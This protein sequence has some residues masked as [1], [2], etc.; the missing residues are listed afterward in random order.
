MNLNI[1]LNWENIEDAVVENAVRDVAQKAMKSLKKN[2]DQ[3][4]NVDD[5]IKRVVQQKPTPDKPDAFI[6]ASLIDYHVRE[7]IDEHIDEILDS[8]IKEAVDRILKR[9]IFKDKIRDLTLKFG[10][11]TSE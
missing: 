4:W 8:A 10:G 7:Y 5:F 2:V 3:W 6:V 9:K 11:E 1:P